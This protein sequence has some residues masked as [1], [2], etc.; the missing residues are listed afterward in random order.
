M[1]ENQNQNQNQNK[2]A[3]N[4]TT[5]GGMLTGMFRDRESTENAYNT[6]HE[7][8]YSKDDI[9]LVMS[10]KTRKKHFSGDVKETE[11]GTKAAEGAGKGSAIGGTVGAIAGVIAAIGTSLAE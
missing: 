8:G 4:M 10:E 1:R 7:R 9:N 3:E 11:I 6:L 5:E 2:K